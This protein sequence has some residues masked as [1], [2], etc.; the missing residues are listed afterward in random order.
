LA[1]DAGFSEMVGLEIR[2]RPIQI[3]LF[4]HPLCVLPLLGWSAVQGL[5][6]GLG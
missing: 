1:M 6:L 4:F 3:H 2:T 5:P